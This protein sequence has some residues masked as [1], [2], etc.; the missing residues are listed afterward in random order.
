[1]GD[2]GLVPSLYRDDPEV[3]RFVAW[4]PLADAEQARR[5]IEIE[6]KAWARGDACRGWLA[7]DRVDG[8]PVG[9]VIAR[10]HEGSAEFSYVIDKALWGRGYA[11][12]LAR[13]LRQRARLDAGIAELWAVCDVE[14]RASLLVLERAGFRFDRVLPGH[15]HHRGFSERRDCKRFV[16][17]F[18]KKDRDDG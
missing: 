2:E 5:F 4:P 17:A 11:T 16:A 18:R 10:R 15:G 12:E 1:M 14:N 8:T 13:A 7:R 6:A 3:T 9:A